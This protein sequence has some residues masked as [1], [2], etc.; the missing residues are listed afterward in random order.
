MNIFT[1][2]TEMYRGTSY[3]ECTS[4]CIK[5]STK[6]PK[7]KCNVFTAV[8]FFVVS[9]FVCTSPWIRP[10]RNNKVKDS[11]LTPARTCLTV[12][13]SVLH[14]EGVSSDGLLAGDAHEAM[15]VPGLLQGIHH[16]LQQH[17]TV[18]GRG[19]FCKAA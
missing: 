16:L 11:E 6:Y 14:V 8:L 19:G 15:H 1:A 9:I 7:C 12:R 13:L 5:A 17:R 4:L 2:P 18:E 3:T 10:Q